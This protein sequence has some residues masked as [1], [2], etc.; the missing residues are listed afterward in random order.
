MER[1]LFAF[2]VRLTQPLAGAVRAGAARRYLVARE[3]S[4]D[5]HTYNEAVLGMSNTAYCH[6]IINPNNWGGGIELSIL[7]K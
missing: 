2:A 5:P 4:L 7:A 1:A 6:W 3:V